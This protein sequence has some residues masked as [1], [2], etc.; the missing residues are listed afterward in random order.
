MTRRKSENMSTCIA[1]KI[2]TTSNN[3]GGGRAFSA[4]AI[5][6]N[7]LES[8]FGGNASVGPQP[9]PLALVSQHCKNNNTV[10]WLVPVINLVATTSKISYETAGQTQLHLAS[11]FVAAAGLNR[12]LVFDKFWIYP[13]KKQK[14]TIDLWSQQ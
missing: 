13:A 9:S 11:P 10:Q 2:E 8:F 6:L 14:R 1:L 12:W 7:S 5:L 3:P 4:S